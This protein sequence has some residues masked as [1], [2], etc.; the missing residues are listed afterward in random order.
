M[1]M[2]GCRPLNSLDELLSMAVLTAFWWM[3]VVADLYL[4]LLS[5]SLARY[6]W[7]LGLDRPVIWRSVAE[8]MAGMLW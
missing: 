5:G 7:M 8:L 3:L 4:V 1:A 6:C 2:G